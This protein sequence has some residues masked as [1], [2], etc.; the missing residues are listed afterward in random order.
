MLD[1][2][3]VLRAVEALRVCAALLL[4]AGQAPAVQ[5]LPEGQG[6][7]DRLVAEI[8]LASRDAAVLA[9]ACAVLLRRAGA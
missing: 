7:R 3:L 9:D 2:E 4:Q 1:E 8:A 5:R 6:A